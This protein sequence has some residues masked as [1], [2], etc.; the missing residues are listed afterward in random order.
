MS[1]Q[2]ILL[3]NKNHI[4]ADVID[5]NDINTTIINVED[6]TVTSI[7]SDNLTTGSIYSNAPPN[8]L[9]F[10]LTKSEGDFIKVGTDLVPNEH[11]VQSLGIPGDGF[12][13]LYALNLMGHNTVGT[14][15][16]NTVRAPWGLILGTGGP[17]GTLSPNILNYYGEVTSSTSLTGF[18]AA[19]LVYLDTVRI[20]KIININFSFPTGTIIS[21]NTALTF[22][23]P[24]NYEPA[25]EIFLPI[26]VLVNNVPVN[27]LM[28]I[29]PSRLCT[30]YANISSGLFTANTLNCGIAGPI[31]VTYILANS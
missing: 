7:V 31:T 20:G 27:S 8:D 9:C 10:D 16:A 14:I 29:N 3:P 11:N 19:T 23:V 1:I 22:E 17:S 18:T 24:S 30:I 5:A 2:N 12:N 25:Q 6:L 4:Y 21:S 13:N 15:Y 28:T 26:I